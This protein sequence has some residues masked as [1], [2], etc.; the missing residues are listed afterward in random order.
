MREIFYEALSGLPSKVIGNTIGIGGMVAT[1]WPDQ[2]RKWVAFSMTPEQIRIFG[3]CA[4]ILFVVYWGLIVWLKPKDALRSAPLAH[5]STTH[6]PSSPSILGD[7]AHVH[8]GNVTNI[9]VPPG[10]DFVTP[11]YDKERADI[12]SL[13]RD[14]PWIVSVLTRDE[15]SSKF[16]NQSSN[17]F[18]A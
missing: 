13:N 1:A 12:T 9:N 14:R 10:R 5:S 15:E 11:R 16:A 3:I 6:G 7:G 4:V 17:T 2:F 18:V 8:Y